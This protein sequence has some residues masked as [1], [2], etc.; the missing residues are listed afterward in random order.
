MVAKFL[1]NFKRLDKSVI[2][3]LLLGLFACSDDP[4]VSMV[5]NGK[6][7]SCQNKTLGEMVDGFMGS[8]SWSSG[9]ADNNQEFV[10]IKGRITLSGKEV[11]ALIQFFVNDNRFKYN[12][13]EFNGVPQNNLMAMGLLSKMCK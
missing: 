2:L 3:L 13:L 7:D 4:R 8:P 12:A 11:D 10:N 9:V 5:K 6:L 1:L